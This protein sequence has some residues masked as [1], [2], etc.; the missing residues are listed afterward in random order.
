MDYIKGVCTKSGVS[1]LATAHFGGGGGQHKYKRKKLKLDETVEEI[2][3]NVRNSIM[4]SRV[5]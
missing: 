4:Q 2:G 3:L 5:Q 1:S